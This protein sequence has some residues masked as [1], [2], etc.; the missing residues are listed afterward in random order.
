MPRKGKIYNIFEDPLYDAEWAAALKDPV[1]LARIRE[2]EVEL[3]D[4]R[5]QK[6]LTQAIELWALLEVAA[7]VRAKKSHTED[8]PTTHLAAAQSDPSPS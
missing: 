3:N 5:S 7:R 8:A 1:F 2:L 6:H 4:G